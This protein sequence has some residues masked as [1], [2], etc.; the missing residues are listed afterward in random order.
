MQLANVRTAFCS[1]S[2]RFTAMLLELRLPSYRTVLLN[3][4][5]VF[6]CMVAKCHNRIVQ[7]LALLCPVSVFV[8][9]V[10]SMG[11]SCLK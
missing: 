9:S 2:S 8:L 10:C 4:A 1:I 7:F 6:R 11:R 3:S 5:S